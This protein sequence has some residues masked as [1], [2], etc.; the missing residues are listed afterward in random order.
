LPRARG[1]LASS[2]RGWRRQNRDNDMLN[3]FRE[4]IARGN[5]MDLAVGIGCGP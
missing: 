4:F 3:E 1:R 5:V 2:G